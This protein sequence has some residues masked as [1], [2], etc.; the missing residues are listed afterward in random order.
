MANTAAHHIDRVL[1]AVPLRQRVLSLLLELRHLAAFR[2]DVAG[3]LGGIFIEAVALKQKREANIAGS[4]H[5][6]VNHFQR[7]RGSLNLNLHFHAI[8]ADG[9][10]APDGAGQIC[11]HS[12]APLTQ[13]ILDRVGRRV[14]ERALRWLR[15]RGLLDERLAEERGNEQRR[16]ASSWLRA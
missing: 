13:D 3:V 9:I 15:K 2:G 1:T 14:R 5:A 10:F 12:L 6:A 4:Q 11:F 7:S 16:Q 8:I